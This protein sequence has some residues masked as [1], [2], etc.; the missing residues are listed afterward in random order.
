MMNKILSIKGLTKTF[1]NKNRRFTA[2]N[3]INVDVFHGE[4]VGLI[5]ESGSGKTTVA[6]ITAGLLKAD[7]GE[8]IFRNKNLMNL[9]E[10]ELYES[11]KGMQMIFQN[12]KAS[13]SERMTI[14][15]SIMEGLNYYT[16][17]S[18]EDKIKKVYEAMEMVKLPRKYASKYSFEISGGE[19]QR[20]AIARAVIIRPCFLICDEITS[21]IDVSVQSQIIKLLSELK[22][23]LNM[24]YLFISHDLA[25]VKNFCSRV[26]VMCKGDVV[27]MNKTDQL[28]KEPKHEYT[29]LLINSVLTI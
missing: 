16:V 9:S 27:E 14:F 20:A 13:F 4:C 2:V 19:C 12:P 26:Y 3:A 6:N 28:F 11:R 25:L 29:Q 24:S 21:A 23:E 7:A 17:F 5:G 1:I 8:I 10:Q 22:K 18:K 15:S